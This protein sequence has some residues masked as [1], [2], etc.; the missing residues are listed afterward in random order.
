M[1]INRDRLDSILDKKAVTC[2]RTAQNT[3][4]SHEHLEDPDLFSE[5]EECRLLSLPEN[6]LTIGEVLGKRL[7]QTVDSLQALTSNLLEEGETEIEIPRKRAEKKSEENYIPHDTPIHHGVLK[8]CKKSGQKIHEKDL[9]SYEN[10]RKFEKSLI[11]DLK[12]ALPYGE[13]LG[14]K[15]NRDLPPLTPIESSHLKKPKE[16]EKLAGELTRKY[17]SVPEVVL[18]DKTGFF[19]GKLIIDRNFYM[20]SKEKSSIVKSVEVKVIT[21]EEYSQYSETIMDVQ[22]VAVKEGDSPLGKGVT[23]VLDGVVIMVTGTDENGVQIGEFGSSEGIL[24]ENIGWNRPG[25][26]DMGDII[27]KTEVVIAAGMNMERPG[28]LAAHRV[29]DILTGEIRAE[30]KKLDEKFFVREETFRH[31]RRKGERKVLLVKEIMGQGAMHDNLI[32]PHQPVGVAGAKANIDLGN[33]P[34]VLSP[35][36]VLDGAIHALTCIGPASKECSRHYFREPLVMEAM[37]DE[38]L[39]LCGVV[40][41]G[42][43]QINREKF[44]VSERLG[45]MVETMDIEGAIVTTEGFGNNHIDFASHIEEIGKRGIPVVGMTFSAQQGA[46]LVGNPH[47]TMMVDL[48]KTPEGIENEILAYNTLCQ[49][50]ALRALEMLKSAMEGY[51]VLP[52]EKN[53]NAQIKFENLQKIESLRGE[54]L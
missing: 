19:E 47:M 24:F 54:E 5:L 13:V 46:L 36:E 11:L 31:Y 16:H 37:G 10:I 1:S 40:F 39:D 44:Y 33:L 35:L 29:T 14:K 6:T 3:L 12:N 21:P 8:T 50:D 53:W 32:L 42:S 22:P 25:S 15:L 43:P 49:E 45:M 38:K 18:G 17:Y 23:R 9:E 28:P 52:P 34:V 7:T 4:I 51:K 2:C 30:L 26:P 41:I 20:K 27:I 48:N